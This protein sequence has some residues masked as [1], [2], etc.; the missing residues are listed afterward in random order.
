MIYNSTELWI[1][2]SLED[3]P[4]DDDSTMFV[5]D[6][7]RK[8][9][10]AGIFNKQ[11]G[12]ITGETSHTVKFVPA[13]KNNEDILSRREVARGEKTKRKQVKPKKAKHSVRREVDEEKQTAHVFADLEEDERNR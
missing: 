13:E 10:L 2:E 6:R 4:R 9:E 11:R 8:G 12:R 1:L 3:F 7:Q 5:Q